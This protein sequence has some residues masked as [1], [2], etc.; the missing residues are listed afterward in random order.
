MHL[1][2]AVLSQNP[3]LHLKIG[4]FGAQSPYTVNTQFD[5]QTAQRPVLWYDWQLLINLKQVPNKKICNWLQPLESKVIFANTPL[6][7][8][9]KFVVFVVFVVV[10]LGIDAPPI[11]PDIVVLWHTPLMRM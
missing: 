1:F 7:K 3:S 6:G 4:V 8:I 2:K 11:T 5:R 9:I 10:L